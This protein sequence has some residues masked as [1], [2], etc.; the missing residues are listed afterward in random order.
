MPNFPHFSFGAIF[1]LYSQDS[2]SERAGIFI[3]PSDNA[4]ASKT[5]AMP[6]TMPVVIGSP[7]N[8]HAQIDAVAGTKNVTVTALLAP[9]VV[10]K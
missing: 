8:N 10:I 5:M 9:S 7:S 4:V 1:N 3:I 6:I 2:A